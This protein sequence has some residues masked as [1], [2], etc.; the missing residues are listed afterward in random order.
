MTSR[1]L[2]DK[3][4][5]KTTANTV[6]MPSG[7]VIQFEKSLS[8][9]SIQATSG[10]FVDSGHSLVITPK[11]SNSYIF[12]QMFAGGTQYNSGSPND[13]AIRFKR[14]GTVIFTNDR[15]I[16]SEDGT[17]NGINYATA[18]IDSPSSTSTL[19]YTFEFNGNRSRFN[20]NSGPVNTSHFT[21]MEIAQ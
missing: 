17:W 10:T 3:I 21:A 12:L 14:N 4:E 18:Y 1:L 13:V 15:H 16:Y 11:F 7:S 9:T 19:T 5:G 8:T 2:V 20:D 6:Q